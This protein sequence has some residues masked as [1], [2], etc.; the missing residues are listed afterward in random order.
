MKLITEIPNSYDRINNFDLRSL[1]EDEGSILFTCL[2]AEGYVGNRPSD[3]EGDIHEDDTWAIAQYDTEGI[4]IY[5]SFLYSSESE[6]RQ[7]LEILGLKETWFEVFITYDDG[8]VEIIETLNS[9]EDAKEYL[10][11]CSILNVAYSE[12]FLNEEGVKEK[13]K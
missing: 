5:D 12:W 8:E 13:V 3:F 6:Y 11:N 1:L 7:D 10:D 2:R 9:E 4:V